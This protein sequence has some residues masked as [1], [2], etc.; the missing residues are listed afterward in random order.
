M[1]MDGIFVSYSNEEPLS[2]KEKILQPFLSC[3]LCAGEDEQDEHTEKNDGEAA[4]S[5]RTW[6]W[7]L[8]GMEFI[9]ISF[10]EEG[11]EEVLRT[12]GGDKTMIAGIGIGG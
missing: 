9:R 12:F 1:A 2:W 3:G 8:S 5:W 6:I 7:C 10:C 11:G 4:M